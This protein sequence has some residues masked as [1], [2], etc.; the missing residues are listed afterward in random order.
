MQA[1][2]HFLNVVAELDRYHGLGERRGALPSRAG[3]TNAV[4]PRRR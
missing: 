2:P 4:S 3:R 1:I